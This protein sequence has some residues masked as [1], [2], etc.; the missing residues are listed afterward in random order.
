MPPMSAFRQKCEETHQGLSRCHG[1]IANIKLI[2]FGFNPAFRPRHSF[3]RIGQY[4]GEKSPLQYCFYYRSFARNLANQVFTIDAIRPSVIRY[5]Q[6]KNIAG[7][8]PVAM[9]AANPRHEH[10]KMQLRLRG[11]S[12]SK[13]AAEIG[14]Y[15]ASV[16]TVSQ[17]LRRSKRI[18]LALA[19]A[20]GTTVQKLFPER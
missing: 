19:D 12:M 20:V 4:S 2:S 7:R 5:G 16:T 14:V 6:A 3:P 1:F 15:P 8:A 13:I 10:L 17:G 11:T 9:S 18:E